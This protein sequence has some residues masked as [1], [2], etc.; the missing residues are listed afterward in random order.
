[1]RRETDHIADMVA[2][3]RTITDYMAG[4]NRSAFNDDAMRQ[5]AVIWQLLIIGEATKRLSEEFRATHPGVPWRK[6][7]GMRD[8]LIHAYDQV[9]LNEVWRVAT[10][11]IPPLIAALEP[12][13]PPIPPD[14]ST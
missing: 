2:A 5:D 12:L 7:A 3:A 13:L 11:D 6:I 10:E 8:V 1:M 4:M 9:S 14:A